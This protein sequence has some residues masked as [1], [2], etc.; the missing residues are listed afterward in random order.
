MARVKTNERREAILAAA[1]QVFQEMSFDQA[2]MDIIAARVGSSKATIYRYFESKE[3]LFSEL[4]NRTAFQQGGDIIKIAFTSAGI[5]KDL[6]PDDHPVDLI[7]ILDTQQDLKS[8]L[9]IFGE[10]ILSTFYTPQTLS[11]QRM[12][13]AASVNPEV[14]RTFFEN[15]AQ[16]AI[17]YVQKFFATHIDEG[18][19]LAFDPRVVTRHYFALITAEVQQESLL[20]VLNSIPSHEIKEIVS[21]SVD[22]FLRAYQKT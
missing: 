22:A 19:L 13:I 2:S 6:P 12:M 1:T 3:S 5:P 14:G 20:N 7:G 4:I 11:V 18:R 15:G 9:I 16:K 17:H 21:R 10:H 8:T